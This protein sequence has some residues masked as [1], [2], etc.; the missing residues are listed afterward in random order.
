MPV[1]EQPEAAASQNS[2]QVTDTGTYLGSQPDTTSA[3]SSSEG[4]LFEQHKP[5][6]DVQTK[7]TNTTVTQCIDQLS[8]VSLSGTSSAIKASYEIDRYLANLFATHNGLDGDIPGDCYGL[9]MNTTTEG[10]STVSWYDFNHRKSEIVIETGAAGRP[11]IPYHKALEYAKANRHNVQ[12]PPGSK[13]TLYHF[14]DTLAIGWT[15]ANGDDNF[16][17]WKVPTRYFDTTSS[18]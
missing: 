2:E 8:K 10:G 6:D 4:V 14:Q 13:C 18:G 12:I 17:S 5:V 15:G 11:T 3:A 16:F 9:F 1:R 7:G